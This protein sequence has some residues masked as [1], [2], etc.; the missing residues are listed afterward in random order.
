MKITSE[1]YAKMY[2]KVSPKSPIFRDCSL[3]FLFG[4]IIC[5]IGQAFLD[6]Y[7]RL[8]IEKKEAQVWVAITLVG[9]GAFLTA[10]KIYDNIAKY[11]GA[12]TIVPITGFANSIVSPAMEFKKEG[13]VLGTGTKM[14]TIAG[15]VLVFGITASIIY[16]L[17]VFVFKLF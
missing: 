14:F 10:L 9:L 16:G 7:T 6:I 13:H 1:E 12:G 8:G 11:A 3:A 4:G 5:V 2:K 15:P 17:I